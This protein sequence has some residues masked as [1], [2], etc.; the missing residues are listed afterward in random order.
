MLSI[1]LKHDHLLNEDACAN[2]N[3]KNVIEIFNYYLRIIRNRA[4]ASESFMCFNDLKFMILIIG[5]LI[6]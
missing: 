4:E 1:H 3:H 6:V 2:S 5:N